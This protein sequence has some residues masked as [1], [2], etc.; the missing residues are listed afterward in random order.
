MR[1]HFNL[2]NLEHQVDC[3]YT[4]MKGIIAIDFHENVESLY[5]LLKK[6]DIPMDDK[7]IIGIGLY[8]EPYYCR[9]QANLEVYYL[10][11]KD[12][13]FDQIQ[14]EYKETKESPK[15][16]EVEIPFID[17]FKIIK[18]LDVK[19]VTPFHADFDFENI[20]EPETPVE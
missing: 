18:R 8:T 12:K 17:L 3:Q 13:G 11:A 19:L 2:K 20:P 4:D 1:K 5:V 16:L 9:P 7:L 15:K 6:K 14:A 10:D